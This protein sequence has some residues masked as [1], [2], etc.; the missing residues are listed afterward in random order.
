MFE[1]DRHFRPAAI[2]LVS[3]WVWII[4]WLAY[5]WLDPSSDQAVQP[6]DAFQETGVYLVFLVVDF[7]PILVLRSFLLRFEAGKD[8]SRL[9][10]LLAGLPYGFEAFTWAIQGTF[11]EPFFYLFKL[12][13]L[14]I[15]IGIMFHFCAKL[16]TFAENRFGHLELY[17]QLLKWGAIYMCITIP[18]VFL[19]FLAPLALFFG[20]LSV[21]FFFCSEFA[22]AWFLWDAKQI[23][24]QDE[25]FSEAVR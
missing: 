23:P 13:Y 4:G 12:V 25:T 22:L 10:V 5:Q 6:L 2:V 7:Y 3:N 17:S 20:I 11:V 9:L 1:G 19:F 15:W 21:F 8:L 24:D 14:I 16:R 18:S